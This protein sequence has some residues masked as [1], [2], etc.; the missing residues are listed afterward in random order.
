MKSIKKTIVVVMGKWFH[1]KIGKIVRGGDLFE[2]YRS[3]LD[4]FTKV[5]VPN[6]NVFDFA[7]VLRALWD[8]RGGKKWHLIWP[9]NSVIFDEFLTICAWTGVIHDDN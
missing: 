7:M 9:E 3:G 6:I 1:K 4:E 2:E 5:M 8:P